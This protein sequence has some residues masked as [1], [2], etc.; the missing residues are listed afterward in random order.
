MEAFG[1]EFLAGAAFSD[2]E[3][4]PVERRSTAGALDR[5][6]ERQALANELVC[7]LHRL[8]AEFCP[9]L[10]GKSHDLARIFDA[11]VLGK[12]RFWRAFLNSRILA[13]NLN[14]EMQVRA[15]I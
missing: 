2:D 14:R 3:N 12:W 1:D 11:F 7:A 9:T 6:E 10:G 4:R 13:R 15:L 8:P 5:V